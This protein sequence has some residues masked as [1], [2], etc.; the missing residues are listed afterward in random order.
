MEAFILSVIEQYGYIGVFF[1]IAIENIFPPIP[2]EVILLFAGFASSKSSL[3]VYMIILIS[4]LGSLV[5]AFVLYY[6][7][8]L[9]NKDKLKKLVNGKIGRMICLKEEDIDKA[10]TWFENKGASAVFFCRFVPI[11]RSLISIPSGMNKM[12]LVKFSMYTFSATLIWNSVLVILGNGVGENWIY[13]A[14]LL[15]KYSSIVLIAIIV[16]FIGFLLFWIF[17]IKKTR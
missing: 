17:K 1:L 4:T 9:L 6:A 7:G 2:S 16:S 12:N 14:Q 10:S 8:T 13:I 15:D 5:G 3:N 11:I